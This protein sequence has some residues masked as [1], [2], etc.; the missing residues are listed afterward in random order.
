[1]F[2]LEKVDFIVVHHTA[3]LAT[4]PVEYIRAHHKEKRGWSDI[5][6]HDLVVAGEYGW[7]HE[8]GRDRKYIGAHTLGHNR[9]SLGFAFGGNYDIEKLPAGAMAVGC[10]VL[11]MLC[12]E[13]NLNPMEGGIKYHQEFVDT[14]CPGRNLINIW[15]WILREV[16]ERMPIADRDFGGYPDEG[17]RK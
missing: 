10:N 13:Y 12:T 6:Y 7:Y 1:M 16:Y 5:G 4:T 17:R 8:R 2:L 11:A 9:F 14:A 3:M 15:P